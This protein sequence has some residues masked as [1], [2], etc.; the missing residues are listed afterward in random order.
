MLVSVEGCSSPSILFLVSDHLALTDV[1]KT[2]VVDHV[3]RRYILRI[4][5]LLVS[6]RRLH[7]HRLGLSYLALIIV[8]TSI[9]LSA[10]F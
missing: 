7:I 8:E 3:R 4:L 6:F 9:G 1:E 2:Q 10:E 5:C